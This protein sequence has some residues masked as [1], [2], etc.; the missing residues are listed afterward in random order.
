VIRTPHL[1]RA[2]GTL[3]L[4][5]VLGAPAP[6][7]AEEDA[8]ATAAARER[9]KEG[10]TYFDEKQY[11]KA[12]A[13]FVQAYALK[14]HPAVLL[15]L[16][17][18]ELRSNHER[19]AAEHFAQYLREATD[20]A[21][22]QREAAQAGL[23]SAKAA[24]CELT[25]TADP[26]SDISVDGTLQGTS[27]LP[28]P[29]YLEPGTHTVQAKK[30]ERL[31]NQSVTAKAGE[32][33]EL[34]L[35]FAPDAAAPTTKPAPQPA[36]PDTDA[37]PSSTDEEPARPR[38]PG[39]EPFFHW[40]LT[41]PAGVITGGATVLFGGG[42]VGFA[43]ASNMAYSDASDAGRQIEDRARKDGIT[44]TT[45]ICV[46]P[47]QVLGPGNENEVAQFE[48]ACTSWKDS[49]DKGDSYKR[50]ATFIGIGAGVMAAAT[51]TLYFLTAESGESSAAAGS[52]VA[53]V[54]WL[55]SGSGGVNVSGRF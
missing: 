1:R 42:A 47:K 23:A 15:N 50:L 44:D 26:D 35:K 16:A 29:L 49:N 43:I 2:L 27:P 25:V 45:G 37:P 38:P 13:A 28:G 52:H 9:F 39:R 22:A 10:V 30:G 31:V 55:D 17:Q 41:K 36:P 3:L 8:T 54:P 6:A 40:L 19:D 32:S 24:I 21:P 33:R 51:V 18:S 34:K 53:V 11:E 14:K 46:D 48:N 5:S 7:R 12:R 4:A 20:A